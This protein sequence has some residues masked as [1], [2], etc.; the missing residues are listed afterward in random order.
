MKEREPKIVENNK[1]TIF[2]SGSTANKDCNDLLR[3]LLSMR[4]PMGVRRRFRD[5]EANP[6]VDASELEFCRSGLIAPCSA[7]EQARRSG[8]PI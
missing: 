7:R 5:R 2:L 6:F 8:H 3:D 1:N 4:A